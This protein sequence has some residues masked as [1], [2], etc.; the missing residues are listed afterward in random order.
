MF[1]EMFVSTVND[2][3]WSYVCFANEARSLASSLAS[4]RMKVV[5]AWHAEDSTFPVLRLV[6]GERIMFH[7]IDGVVPF[8]FPNTN[9]TK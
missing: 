5:Q 3:I 4:K 7:I 6:C 9:Y 1:V 8:G 2:Q